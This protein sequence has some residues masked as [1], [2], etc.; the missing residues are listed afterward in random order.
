MKSRPLVPKTS[1]LPLSYT[2]ICWYRT[3]ESN[4]HAFQRRIL[5][6]VGLPIPPR[7]RENMS[8]KV[9]RRVPFGETS[10]FTISPQPTFIGRWDSNP[11]RTGLDNHQP[12]GCSC[13]G[14]A[15]G[16][17]THTPI[18]GTT[19]STLRDSQFLHSRLIGPPGRSRTCNTFRI[20]PV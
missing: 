4:R 6:A 1:A 14:A 20:S 9:R 18:T 2:L 19:R 15:G 10:A 13:S 11:Q 16:I 7:A 3:S 12:F 8:N 5:S 17:R